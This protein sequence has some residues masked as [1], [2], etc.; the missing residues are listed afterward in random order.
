MMLKASSQIRS[1]V[2][3]QTRKVRAYSLPE[4]FFLKKREV[5]T[6]LWRIKRILCHFCNVFKQKV[7]VKAFDYDPDQGFFCFQVVR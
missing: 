3:G 5:L 1:N 4:D 2:K 6:V 7:H